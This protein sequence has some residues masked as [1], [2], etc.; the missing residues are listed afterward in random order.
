MYFSRQWLPFQRD[1]PVTNW[2]NHMDYYVHI[3]L[4]G[5]EKQTLMALSS[6]PI[7][8][9]ERAEQLEQLRWLEN[10]Y[11]IKVGL[12]SYISFGID[13]PDDLLHAE[14]NWDSYNSFPENP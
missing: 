4:Y 1:I 14:T 6:L 13:T 5:F 7:S 8:K 10:G 2:A 9:L 3:G 11:Q 12:T